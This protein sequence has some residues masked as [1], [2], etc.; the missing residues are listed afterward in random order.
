MYV[1]A[2]VSDD[3]D[4]DNVSFTI[5]GNHLKINSS[6]DDEI[7]S[8]YSIRLKTTDVDELSFEKAFTL[9]VNDLKEI[10]EPY[11]KVYTDKDTISFVT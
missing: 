10:S 9:T 2:L 6:P 7:Q 8:S 3:G 11:Q 5:D 4:T 1:Y